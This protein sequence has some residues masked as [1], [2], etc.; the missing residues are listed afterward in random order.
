M[1]LTTLP[2][3]ALAIALFGCA[4]QDEGNL[5]T[6]PAPVAHSVGTGSG[7]GGGGEG[8]TTMGLELTPLQG[9][10]WVRTCSNTSSGMRISE[11][12]TCTDARHTQNFSGVKCEG[13]SN[14]NQ[15]TA[16]STS[17]GRGTSTGNPAGPPKLTLRQRY[18]L[19]G[20]V[21]RAICAGE[22]VGCY[23]LS[24]LPRADGTL[25]GVKCMDDDNGSNS[26]NPRM[27][28]PAGWSP[29]PN[30]RTAADA[31]YCS[32]TANGR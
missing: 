2:L 20:P 19:A 14:A 8:L 23:P 28:C 24:F 7:S 9:C 29:Y 17:S 25:R 21:A 18:E 22:C 5:P 15:N 12:N 10:S 13:V 6:T 32:Q 11:R 30:A 4:P 26:I 1:R 31:L 27:F 3:A 16:G